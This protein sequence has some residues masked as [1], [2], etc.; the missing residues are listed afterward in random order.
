[1]GEILAWVRERQLDGDLADAGEAVRLV[2]ET[3][4][5]DEPEVPGR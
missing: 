2:R 3:F 4:P 1:M 5:P